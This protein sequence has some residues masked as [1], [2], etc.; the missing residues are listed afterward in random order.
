MLT[1]L[2]DQ[3]ALASAQNA[4]EPVVKAEGVNHYFGEGSL[5]KQILFDISFALQ[6]GEIVLLTGPSGSGKTTLLTLLGALRS[7]QEGSLRVLGQE[8]R[9]A[10]PSTLIQIRRQVG[11]I[12]QA[13]N[14]LR[15]LTAA[16]NVRM[17]LELHNGLSPQEAQQR[18]E[19]CAGN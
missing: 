15:S 8:L 17:A 1:P 12:F 9:G 3:A 14:L 2:L 16:Q 4:V 13:H 18:A 5:R 10:Q 19:K 7:V 6:P 11:Y